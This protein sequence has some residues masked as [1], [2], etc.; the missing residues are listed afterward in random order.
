MNW[1]NTQAWI[2]TFNR[3]KEL[4]RLVQHFNDQGA[5]PCVFNNHPVLQLYPASITEKI[6]TNSLN[7]EKSN[8]WCARSWNTALIQAFVREGVDRVICIQDDTDIS[9]NFLDWLDEASKRYDFI[10]GPAGDQFF[11]I[12]KDLFKKVGWW[13]ERYIGCYCGDAD[14]MKRVFHAA[15]PSKV[16]I[17]DTHNWGFHHN[18]CGLMNHVITTYESKTFAGNYV[19]QH[20]DLEKRAPSTVRHSQAHYKRKWGQ[21]LDN[22]QPLV[23]NS[24]TKPLIPEID[25]YPWASNLLGFNDLY[26]AQLT[27]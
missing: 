14:W 23:Y 10:W 26:D 5:H 6:I 15:D 3:P 12:T 8:S 22:G 27:R 4:N 7:T 21:D 16:S 20:W 19:N 18:D 9:P 2:L 11:Y 17:V 1:T 13:D 25:W 24:V